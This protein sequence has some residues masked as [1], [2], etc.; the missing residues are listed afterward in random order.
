MA[1][2]PEAGGTGRSRPLSGV[3]PAPPPRPPV[4]DEKLQAIA[5]LC[6]AI[7]ARLGIGLALARDNPGRTPPAWS[8]TARGNRKVLTFGIVDRT[9]FWTW[10]DGVSNHYSKDAATMSRV[11]LEEMRRFGHLA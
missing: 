6:R 11:I 7:K 2:K 4:V 3:A 10:D 8:V 1:D 9:F 5:D